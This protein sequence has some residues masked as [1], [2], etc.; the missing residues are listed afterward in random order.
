MIQDTSM[1]RDYFLRLGLEAAVGD[2][3]LALAAHGP[4]T[5]S[6][7]SRRSGVERT[8]IYRLIDSLQEANLVE[9]ES[10]YKRSIL[11]AAPIDNVQILLSK[12]EERLRGLH[13][14]F[15]A[16]KSVITERAKQSHAARVQSYRG[17]EGLKQ[18]FWNQTGAKDKEN[19]SILY[20]S[21]QNRAK[22]AFFERWVR[23][24]NRRGLKSRS[25]I[26]DRFLENQKEWYRNK[27]N[28]RIADFESRYVPPEVFA[29][30]HSMVIHD[31]TVS[32]YN[33]HGGAVFGVEI[34][35]KEIADAQRAFFEMLW[36]KSEPVK[37]AASQQLKD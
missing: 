16:I 8:R 26:G 2:V 15:E 28:E 29:I 11:Q 33:W 10:H 1:L 12:E 17:I 21:M 5:I 9:V 18:M 23:E 14:E 37:K 34:Q 22:G 20:E 4:Q 32:Y 27:D 3:Y 7:L 30:T 24:F 13:S 35:H 31:D 25:L 19:L 36:E 6:E